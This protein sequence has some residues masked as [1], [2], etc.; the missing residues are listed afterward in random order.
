[1]KEESDYTRNEVYLYSGVKARLQI[2]ADKKKWSLK[3]YME[4]VLENDSKK[5]MKQLIEKVKSI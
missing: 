2:L 1:M 5:A 3:K 4:H